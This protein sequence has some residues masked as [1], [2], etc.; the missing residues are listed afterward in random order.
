MG[1]LLGGIISI[2]VSINNLSTGFILAFGGGNPKVENVRALVNAGAKISNRI[3]DL[4]NEIGNEE[5]LQILKNARI[6]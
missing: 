4:A 6:S 5:V 1:V 3:W 2:S